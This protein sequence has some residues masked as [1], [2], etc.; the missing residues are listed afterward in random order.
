MIVANGAWEVKRVIVP[1]CP[2]ME[3]LRNRTAIRF[4]VELKRRRQRYYLVTLVVPCFILSL[5]TSLVFLLPTDNVLTL[6]VYQGFIDSTGPPTGSSYLSEC[7]SLKVF[8]CNK[9]EVGFK[10]CVMVTVLILVLPFKNSATFV[11]YN[12]YHPFYSE[13][14]R[15]VTL[16]DADRELNVATVLLCLFWTFR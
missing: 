12:F 7:F 3:K 2:E 8:T 4:V 9:G 5:F 14:Y 6:F 10:T 16:L 13:Q 1:D 11:L 15:S